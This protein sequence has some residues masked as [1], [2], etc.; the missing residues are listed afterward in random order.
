[1]FNRKPSQASESASAATP[2]AASAVYSANSAP[3]TMYIVRDKDAAEGAVSLGEPLELR[4]ETTGN[5]M[6]Q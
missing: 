3:L 6:I 1:M 2:A 4:I 5:I